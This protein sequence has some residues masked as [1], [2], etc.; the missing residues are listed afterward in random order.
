MK[1]PFF[2]VFALLVLGVALCEAQP[3]LQ[4][5]PTFSFGKVYKG[6][7]PTQ[8]VTVRNVGRDTLNII[9][10]SAQCGCTAAM[11][12]KQRI[13]PSDSGKL[14]ITF[15][16]AAY[17]GLV[18]K[19]VY[20]QTNDP[21]VPRMTIEFSANVIQ[22]ITMDPTYVSFNVTTLDT[23]CSKIIKLTNTSKQSIRIF[24]A[25]SEMQGLRVSLLQN[26]LMPGE[27]TD[28]QLVYHPVGQTTVQGIINL[29]TDD[30]GQPDIE[31]RV[32]QFFKH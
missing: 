9:D 23:T 13:A 15:N 26:Q 19:H 30:P 5:T 17:E 12:S 14:S 4:T 25:T 29:K 21:S 20:V 1:F 18:T 31:Y 32:F 28:L 10:V 16:T 3:K 8:L 27:Q 22:S 11:I 2:C 7:R 24:S 6:S